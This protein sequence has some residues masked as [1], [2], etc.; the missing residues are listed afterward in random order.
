MTLA[1]MPVMVFIQEWSEDLFHPDYI[2]TAAYKIYELTELEP[3]GV[4]P[5]SLHFNSLSRW[6]LCE[7]CFISNALSLMGYLG[8]SV[9]FVFLCTDSPRA[10]APGLIW[11]YH[12]SVPL[13]C[14]TSG[15]LYC[16]SLLENH[17]LRVTACPLHHECNFPFTSNITYVSPKPHLF[18][19]TNKVT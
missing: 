5:C 9:I 11:I 19:G 6:F 17:V 7:Q 8:I 13:V 15:C 18:V 3:V 2:G 1:A 14:L 16:S 10:R 4:G 12:Y